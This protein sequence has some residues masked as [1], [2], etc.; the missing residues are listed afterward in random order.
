MRKVRSV[1]ASAGEGTRGVEAIVDG[2]LRG[3]ENN[4]ALNNESR[5]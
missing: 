2:R 1:V 4:V 3:V 5:A